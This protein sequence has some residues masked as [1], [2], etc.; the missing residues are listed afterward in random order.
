MFIIQF[1]YFC[2]MIK[3]LMLGV[4]TNTRQ[5]SLTCVR[6]PSFSLFSFVYDF[7]SLP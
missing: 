7:L 4:Q 5:K 1:D 6:Q 2:I 3:K